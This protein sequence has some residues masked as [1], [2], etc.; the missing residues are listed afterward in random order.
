[1]PKPLNLTFGVEIECIVCFDPT[2]Y[3]KGLSFGDGILWEQESP[4]PFHREN[5]LRI[6]LRRHIASVFESKGFSTYD[7]TSPGGDQKWSI[8]GD[9]SISIK[10]GPRADEFLECDIEIKSP[11]LRFCPKALRRVERVVRILTRY[12]DTTVNNSCG[13]HVHIGNRRKGFPIQTLKHFSMLTALFEH[14]L[15]ALHPAHRIGN[16]HVKGPSAAF[17]GQNP[18]DTMRAIQC[19]ESK[20]QLLLLYAKEGCLDRC[21]AYNLCPLVTGPRNTIEFRQHAA[22]LD[23][24]EIMNWI[25]LAGGMVDAMHGTRAVDLAQLI[26]T[27]AFDPRFTVPDLLLKLKLKALVSFYRGRLHVHLRPEPIWARAR[28]KEDADAKPQ[29]PRALER[30]EELERRHNTERLEELKR[31]KELDERH[32]LERRRELERQDEEVDASGAASGT[33]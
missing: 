18:W 12:F 20:E 15:N 23:G 4:S 17:K 22:T 21:F 13:L 8:T 14:Q 29:K 5:K 19:C 11:A 16:Y 31:C 2:T 33:A 7:L 30:L 9:A 24:S 6:L 10:R 25:Q 26:H 1:M 3:E 28:T 27:S 32:E